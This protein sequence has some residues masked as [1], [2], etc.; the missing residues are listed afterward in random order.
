MSI[1]VELAPAA[2]RILPT[3]ARPRR[4][5]GATRHCTGPMILR[6][7]TRS[8]SSE[9]SRPSGIAGARPHS[10]RSKATAPGWAAGARRRRAGRMRRGR[11]GCVGQHDG[12]GVL[13]G[14]EGVDE[15]L[16]E[17]GGSSGGR[18]RTGARA[19][20]SAPAPVDRRLQRGAWRVPG[21]GDAADAGPLGA[22]TSKS[23]QVCRVEPA[24]WPRR[25][26]HSIRR[27]PAGRSLSAGAHSALISSRFRYRCG[28]RR[29]IVFSKE[30]GP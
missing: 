8:A 11:I 27:R 1:S 30:S 9:S 29:S 6:P 4:P 20:P 24:E 13:V 28:W 7:T 23:R 3:T 18:E 16:D 14:G 19:V 26:R 12:G 10:G 2:G 22:S 17:G 5:S 15:L 21:G 25:S